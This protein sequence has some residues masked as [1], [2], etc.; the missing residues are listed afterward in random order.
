MSG[1][2][3]GGHNWSSFMGKSMAEHDDFRTSHHQREVGEH[4]IIES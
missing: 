3:F 2:L 4:F 1:C